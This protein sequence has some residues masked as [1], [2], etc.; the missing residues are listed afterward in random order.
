MSDEKPAESRI[1]ELSIENESLRSQ[2]AQLKVQTDELSKALK[3]A[4]DVI[5]S[6]L[7]ARLAQKILASSHYTVEDLSKM[8][9]DE[10]KGVEKILVMSNA[11]IKDIR[12][13]TVVRERWPWQRRFDSAG[14]NML[15]TCGRGHCAY[16]RCF[17][18]LPPE[19]AESDG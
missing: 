12:I 18:W 13:A 17:G 19:R 3:Q 1:S 5:E 4:N 15:S 11:P 10:L 9:V 2:V 7:K 6:D 16:E 14:V 8:S